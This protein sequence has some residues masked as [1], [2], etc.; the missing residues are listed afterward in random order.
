MPNIR[1][2]D[3]PV[4]SLKTTDMGATAFKQA[5]QRIGAFYDEIG[6]NIG[7]AIA[8][9]G[10]EV[11]KYVEHR[12]VSAGAKDAASMFDTLTQQWNDTAKNADPNDPTV[13]AKFRD[14]VLEPELEKF[15]GRFATEGGQRYA[16]RQV[17]SLRSHMFQKTASDMATLAGQSVVANLDSMT[18]RL[19]NS[20][21]ADPSGLKAALDVVDGSVPDMVRSNPNIN[22]TVAGKI[23]TE[24][25]QNIKEKIA[26]AAFVGAVR[27]NP[28]AGLALAKQPEYS[29]YIN[30]TDMKALETEAR[31]VQRNNMVWS[32][33]QE[34]EAKRQRQEA[35]D[36]KENDYLL[37]LYD[38][39]KPTLG[40]KDI[41]NDDTLSRQAKARL[42]NIL[43]RE[44]KPAT[45]ARASA[46]NY[47]DTLRDIRENKITDR[48]QITDRMIKGDYT[49]A[50]YQQAL[51]D[52]DETKTPTGES[53]AKDRTE[54][55]KRYAP[56]IDP[57]LTS[58]MVGVSG[59]MPGRQSA[60][61]SQK[62]YEAEKAARRV[63][64]DLRKQGKDPHLAYDPSSPEF[65]GKQLPKYRASLQESAAYQAEISKAD[66]KA[67]A[68]D[69]KPP[70]SWQWSE[71]RKQYRDPA[72]MKV[73]DQN[74]KEVP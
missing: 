21:H 9:T 45:A 63:E 46:Q 15:S 67:A 40:R 19:T 73:Y 17:E 3:S 65:F 48:G 26:K 28:D 34:S 10:G 62:M 64:E 39:E 72:T 59:L 13:A 14:E 42:V 32:K 54:F 51:K 36:N 43:E 53:L 6:K 55:F 11:A 24:V 29:K 22:A 57:A 35:S 18:N 49:R 20:V 8:T 31:S 1:Q 52:F 60:L 5:G 37:K 38:S 47:V 33:W 61:G 4:D 66:R 69:F 41:I 50:D 16:E 44:T 2:L 30:A 68:P 25:A 71:S 74:G 56:A 58:D 12:E 23:Q 27:N 70:T 7:S